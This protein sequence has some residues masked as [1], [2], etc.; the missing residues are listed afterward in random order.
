MRSWN[1]SCW[2]PNS[3][4]ADLVYDLLIRTLERKINPLESGMVQFSYCSMNPNHCLLG[5]HCTCLTR[6]ASEGVGFM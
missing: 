3:L 2:L 4:Y 1:I 5:H 6:K